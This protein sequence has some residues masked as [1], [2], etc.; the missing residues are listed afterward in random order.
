MILET[1]AESTRKRVEKA[2]REIPPDVLKE[3]IAGI[4]NSRGPFAFE[5][6]LKGNG[7]SFIC[8]VKKASPSKGE[9]APDFPYKT[10]AR[11]YEEAGARAISVL[12]EPEYFKGHDRYLEEISTLVSIPVLR[13]D[14]IV[15]AY[16]I[17]EAKLL[18]ADAV[19]LICSLLDTQT[20]KEYMGICDGIGL[21]ALVEAHTREEVLSALEAGARVIGVNNRNLRT[22]EVDIRTCITLREMVPDHIVYV[23]ESGIQSREDIAM[24]EKHGVDAVLIG[25]ALMRSPDK[26]AMLACLKGCHDA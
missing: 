22:F 5:K 1:L 17:Y 14:F 15:D 4:K 2:K 10:I 13:K 11:E 24:L 16:Q 26:K 18:G 20:L 25:E 7:I 21:S 23:A 8:E 3:R 9:I 12:T 6:A 19:L